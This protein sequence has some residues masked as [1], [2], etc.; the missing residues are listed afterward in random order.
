MM[1]QPTIRRTARPSSPGSTTMSA[2]TDVAVARLDGVASADDDAHVRARS[3]ATR[4][5]RRAPSCLRRAPRR[6]ARSTSAMV[7]PREQRGVDP[8]GDRLDEDR[9]LVGHVVADAMQLA[10]VGDEL[11]CPAA[12]GRAA[13][14]GLDAGFEIAG[15][16]VGVVVAVAGSRALERGSEA[17]G[18]VT[19]DRF[20]DRRAFRRR[21]SRRS[22]GR[23]RTGSSPS[24]RSTSTRVLR[25]ATGPN[26]R[27]RTGGC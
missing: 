18:F 21:V 3:G 20:D 6:P 17:A 26:R 13:E 16:E 19:E 11:R 25:S 4:R 2:P 9:P 24:R 7:G 27:C 1:W 10:L 15:G 14:P 22:R 8:A 12:A 5:S 23:A